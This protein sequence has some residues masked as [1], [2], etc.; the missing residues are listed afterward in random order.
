[1]AKLAKPKLSNFIMDQPKI[2]RLL[3]IMQLLTDRTR[4]NTIESISRTLDISPRT[5]YR[6]LDTFEN[7]RLQT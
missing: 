5:V 4:I 7:C 1:M 3:R 2:E 6:Y